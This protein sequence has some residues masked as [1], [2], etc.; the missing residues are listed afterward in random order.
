MKIEE[1]DAEASIRDGEIEIKGDVA[2][3]PSEDYEDD[4]SSLEEEPTDEELDK[5]IEQDL[6]NGEEV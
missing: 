6:D 5:R 4:A 2:P 3:M 1:I